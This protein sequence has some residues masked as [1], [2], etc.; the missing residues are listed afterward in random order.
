M[1]QARTGGVSVVLEYEDVLEPLVAL[2]VLNALLEG[3]EHLLHVRLRNRGPNGTVVGGFYDNLVSPNAAHHIVHPFSDPAQVAFDHEGRKLIWHH[4][5][6]PAFSVG[7]GVGRTI[8]QHFRRGLVF[9]AVAKRAKP[10]R[11]RRLR[12]GEVVRPLATFGG[13]DY[14]PT[15]NRVSAKLRHLD[16]PC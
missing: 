15:Y 6:A 2:K 10:A 14:P 16:P 9:V 7:R 1:F 13:D 5:N 8:S 11:F 4:P 12:G 3:L